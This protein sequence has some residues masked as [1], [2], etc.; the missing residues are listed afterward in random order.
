VAP[1]GKIF[2]PGF[3]CVLQVAILRHLKI[4]RELIKHAHQNGILFTCPGDFKGGQVIV[5]VERD[6]RSIFFVTVAN[7]PDLDSIVNVFEGLTEKSFKQCIL[8]LPSPF[9]SCPPFSS[10]YTCVFLLDG[11]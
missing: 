5:M 8:H 9:L 10:P 11:K 1:S 6:F 2:L 3:I 4:Y 7:N